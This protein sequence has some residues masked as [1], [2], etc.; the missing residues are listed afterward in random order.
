LPAQLAY[1]VGCPERIA[2]QEAYGY[3]QARM[4]AVGVGIFG[5]AFVWVFL[6]KN[7]DVSKKTLQTKTVVF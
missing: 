3:G 6:I 4:L 1:P 2:I 7:H 5:L